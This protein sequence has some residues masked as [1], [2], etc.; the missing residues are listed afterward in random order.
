[1][2]GAI[3][4]WLLAFPA[5]LRFSFSDVYGPDWINWCI[6]VGAGCGLVIELL[7]QRC[8]RKPIRFSLRTLLIATTL[9]A[10]VLGIIVWM[11]RAS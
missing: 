10:L 5:F 8:D 6:F 4:G 11:M 2:S 9:I 1:M 7:A 3:L